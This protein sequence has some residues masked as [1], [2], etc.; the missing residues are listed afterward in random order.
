MKREAGRHE[1]HQSLAEEHADLVQ[2][3]ADGQ[4][5]MQQDDTSEELRLSISRVTRCRQSKCV[6]KARVASG[7]R[8][9]VRDY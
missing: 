1:R 4:K 8:P 6:S 5:E 2:D 7:G 3:S 9:Q